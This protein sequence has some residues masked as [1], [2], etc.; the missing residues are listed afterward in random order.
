MLLTVGHRESHGVATDCIPG[1]IM[2]LSPTTLVTHHHHHDRLF[3]HAL[4]SRGGYGLASRTFGACQAGRAIHAKKSTSGSVD[5]AEK[6]SMVD[7][8][9]V[10]CGIHHTR[11]GFRRLSVLSKTEKKRR[12]TDLP[13]ISSHYAPRK[14][15][16]RITSTC[17]PKCMRTGTRFR[18]N[19]GR[20]VLPD[21]KSVV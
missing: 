20:N 15:L 19:V 13:I 11:A 10:D 12:E 9:P 21:R 1:I 3:R 7:H 8:K 16:A 4:V 2:Q 14:L 17:W 18:S 6:H 5:L